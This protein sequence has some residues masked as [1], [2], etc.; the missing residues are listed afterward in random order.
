MLELTREPQNKRGVGEFFRYSKKKREAPSTLGQLRLTSPQ[1]IF[2]KHFVHIERIVEMAPARE[3]HG[4]A[5]PLA[6]TSRLKNP[7]GP[8]DKPPKQG[9][10]LKD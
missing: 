8:E 5:T 10:G 9:N 7:C 2:H 4:M 3:G 1:T 6:H